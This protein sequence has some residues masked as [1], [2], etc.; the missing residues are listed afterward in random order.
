[1]D[2]L[3]ALE[4]QRLDQIEQCV[5]LYR[6]LRSLAPSRSSVPNALRDHCVELARQEVWEEVESLKLHRGARNARV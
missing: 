3:R 4:N 5:N 2:L 1:M 6:H